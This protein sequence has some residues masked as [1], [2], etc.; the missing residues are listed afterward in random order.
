MVVL[1]MKSTNQSGGISQFPRWCDISFENG[2]AYIRYGLMRTQ[3][4]REPVSLTF[5]A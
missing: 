5:T 2:A 3:L 4:E 1:Y